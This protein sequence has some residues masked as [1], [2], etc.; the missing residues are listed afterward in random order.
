MKRKILA[1]VL[2][3]EAAACIL[4]H[5][6]KA[7]YSDAF[8]AAMAFPFEQI[9]KWL[10][11]LSLSGDLGN[12]AAIAIFAALS[13]SPFAALI[14]LRTRRM[15]HSEDGL[16]ALLGAVLPAILY[17]MV[18]PGIMPAL[19]GPAIEG[20]FGK[21]ALGSIVYSM[22]CG[23]IAMRALRA[24]SACGP[25]KLIR[26]TASMLCIV[27]ALFVYAAFGSSF[28]SLL[29]SIASLRAGNAGNEHLLGVTYIFLVLRYIIEALPYMFDVLIIFAALRLLDEFLK[30]RFSAE[31]V[32]STERLSKL[33]SFALAAT[34]ISGIA[35][36]ILQLLFA[37]SLMVFDST[38]QIPVLS[39]TFVLAALL[40]ARFA[41]E[42]KSLK[43]DLDKFI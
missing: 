36:N 15:L 22:L 24:F 1:G 21:A 38:V 35:I 7:S 10:R 9:G 39:I 32:A 17:L 25:L 3:C 30:N 37:K 6:A 42:S 28:G 18:N 23:Y 34:V 8:S 29:D 11:M 16:L 33:C 19:L 27:N 5:L 2:I 4:L 14:V 20:A 43:D 31:A 40:L 26:Y 12:I 41:N 13:L